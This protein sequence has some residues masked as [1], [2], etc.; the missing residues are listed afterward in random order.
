MLHSCLEVR[1]PSTLGLQQ[2]S[3]LCEHSTS[4][5]P[6]T[7]AEGTGRGSMLCRGS[8]G[9]MCLQM[10]SHLCLQQQGTRITH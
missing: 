6:W 8:G 1:V 5:L 10:P 7:G 9:C 4:M 3:I 2:Q